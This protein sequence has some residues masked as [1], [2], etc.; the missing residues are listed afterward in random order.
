MLKAKVLQEQGK[1]QQEIADALGVTDRTVRNYLKR[2][3]K[4]KERRKRK[5]KLDGQKALI[6]QIRNPGHRSG[7]G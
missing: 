5:S 4:R 3:G 6:E 2:A 1:T 7:K